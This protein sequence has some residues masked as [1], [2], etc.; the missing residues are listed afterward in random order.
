[1]ILFASTRSGEH[2]KHKKD[3]YRSTA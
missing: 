1:M 2:V 3:I